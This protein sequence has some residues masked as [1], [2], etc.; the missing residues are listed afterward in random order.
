MG[1]M[2]RSALITTR[3]VAE[4]L[5]VS[6]STLYGWAVAGYGPPPIKVGR[7]VRY[8]ASDV[9][10]WLEQQKRSSANNVG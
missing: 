2:N 8:K 6:R 7:Q 3:D 9:D 10:A 4:M 1:D 5:G